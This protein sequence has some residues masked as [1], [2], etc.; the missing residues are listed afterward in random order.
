MTDSLTIPTG[1]LPL[2]NPSTAANGTDQ[3]KNLHPESEAHLQKACSAFE[4]LFIHYMLK[5][6]RSTVNKSG[7]IDGGQAE[8]IYTSMLDSRMAEDI[9][10]RGG[11]G[12]AR[13]LM[14]Q[15]EDRLRR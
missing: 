13:I 9:S 3:N 12:L 8:E 15:L 14:Q 4:S 11:I 5:E 7:L 6:M 10:E 2:I 1:T